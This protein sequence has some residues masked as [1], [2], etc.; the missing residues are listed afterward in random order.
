M[1]INIPPDVER[2]FSLAPISRFMPDRKIEAT[3]K[4]MGVGRDLGNHAKNRDFDA[5]I[6]DIS[7]LEKT[8]IQFEE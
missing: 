7:R 3:L 8:I 1:V 2:F 6:N 4:C 5:A